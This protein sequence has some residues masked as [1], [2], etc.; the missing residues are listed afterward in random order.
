VVERT[1]V[2]QDQRQ[3]LLA[4]ELVLKA[5]ARAKPPVLPGG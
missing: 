2:A 3:A 5:Q 4:A 1:E